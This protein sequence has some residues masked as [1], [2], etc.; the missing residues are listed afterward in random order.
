MGFD[1]DALRERNPW[2]SVAEAQGLPFRTYAEIQNAVASGLYVLDVSYTAAREFAPLVRSYSGRL[3]NLL[4]AFIPLLTIIAI[5]S[6]AL[7]Q[8]R[9]GLLAGV[10]IVVIAHVFSHPMN[11]L[12]R[13]M[14]WL[15]YILALAMVGLWN[16]TA[17]VLLAA[18]ILPF[19][20]NREMYAGNVRALR[21]ALLR[22]EQHFL[23]QYSKGSLRLRSTGER[24]AEC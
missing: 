19:M 3:L 24:K 15:N 22:S 14:T 6:L 1:E 8:G 23:N 4:F 5:I 21:T 10:P 18:F 12:R 2:K 9:F 13:P 20:A 17:T 11:P 16:K 7:W